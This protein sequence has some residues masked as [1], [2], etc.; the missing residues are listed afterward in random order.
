MSCHGG[1]AACLSVCRGYVIPLSVRDAQR[2]V[3]TAYQPAFSSLHYSRHT[4]RG[5]WRSDTGI[6]RDADSGKG[7][8]QT[9][10]GGRPREPPAHHLRREPTGGRRT[11]KHDLKSYTTNRGLPSCSDRRNPNKKA[12][13]RAGQE[14]AMEKENVRFL[15]VGCGTMYPTRAKALDGCAKP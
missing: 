6:R 9:T 5:G 11:G 14:M 1:L 4:G 13:S 10:T 15:R 8:P 12:T 7:T 2:F 3:L